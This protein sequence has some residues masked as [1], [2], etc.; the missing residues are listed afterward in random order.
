[1]KLVGDPDGLEELKKM[2]TERKD[3][4][5]YIITEAKTN[6]DLSTTFRSSD[7]QTKYKIIY[8]RAA[9]ELSVEKA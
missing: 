7:G 3:Y 1:M 6:T 9:Q 5:K 8:N 2:Q 4:L